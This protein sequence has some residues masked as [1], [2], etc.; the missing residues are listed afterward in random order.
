MTGKFRIRKRS[1]EQGNLTGKPW[2]VDFP[3]GQKY[4]YGPGWSTTASGICCSSFEE[5]RRYVARRVTDL[6]FNTFV[7][8]RDTK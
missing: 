7:Q 6:G 4:H 2:L 8:Y 1:R 5:A 3:E